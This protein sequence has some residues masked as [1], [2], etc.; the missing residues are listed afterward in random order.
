[1]RKLIL[2][3]FQSPGDIVML[4]AAVRD[5]H[6]HYPEQFATDVRTPC[7]ALWENNPHITLLDENDADVEVIECHYP[8]IHRSN[9]T[10]YH[11]LHGFIED[12]NEKLGLAI[13]PTAFKGD[14][15]ISDNEERWF[16]N[17][18]SQHG[19]TTPYWIMV[20]GGKFDFTIKWWHPERYQQVVDALRGRVEFVQIGEDGHHHPPLDGVV[21]L[22]GRTDLRQ[23]VRLMYHAQGVVSPISLPMHL[24][25]AVE[26]KPGE[27]KNRPCVVIAGGREPPHWCS[28]PHHQVVHTVGALQCCDNGGCWKSRTTAL[29]DG[30]YKDNPEELCVDVV[31]GFPRCL[32]M[33]T[34]DEIVRRIESY[35]D[36]GALRYTCAAVETTRELSA[37]LQTTQE[38]NLDD[39]KRQEALGKRREHVAFT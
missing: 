6:F 10:P 14:I 28:Y 12:L 9:E 35:F 23:L 21:D 19:T 25:A 3:N 11:F 36:G 13:K 5:L 39:K 15:H 17:I 24:A 34:A 37:P 29:G 8:L 16:E 38:R 4:T 30:D 20:S 26:T 27:P 2:K 18:E 32:D 7:P 31:E 1:M 22:R 33:I